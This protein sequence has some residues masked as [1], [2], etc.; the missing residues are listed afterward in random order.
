MTIT[1]REA[2]KTSTTA[3]QLNSVSAATSLGVNLVNLEGLAASTV[4]D[5]QDLFTAMDDGSF[6]NFS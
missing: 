6:T 1:I 2:D 5:L 3:E 4:D